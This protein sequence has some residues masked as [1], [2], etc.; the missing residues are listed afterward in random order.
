[1]GKAKLRKGQ[2]QGARS[3]SG[4]KRDRTPRSIGPCDGIIRRREMYGAPAN[5]MDT[6]DALG[7]A[8]Q[9]GLLHKDRERAKQMLD[10]GRKIAGQYW[11]AYGFPTADSL[12]RFQPQNAM[13]TP[14]PIADK[15]REDALNV[16]LA[17]VQGR[18][19]AVRKFFDQLVIDLNHDSGPPPLDRII[20]AHRTKKRASESDYYWLKLAIEGLE[21]IA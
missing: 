7:R 12:A 1:M 21:Q 4:R 18:G 14:D 20:F 8:W 2:P 9:A 16:A 19:R 13:G 11:R 17:M 3:A 15:I 5:D 10:G 6:I